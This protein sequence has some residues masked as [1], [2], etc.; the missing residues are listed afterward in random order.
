VSEFAGIVAVVAALNPPAAALMAGAPV[1]LRLAALG[2]GAGLAI[3]A[4]LALL[5]DPFMDLLDV[6]PESF[7]VAAGVVMAAVGTRWLL[8]GWTRRRPAAFSDADAVH[9]IALPAIAGPAT[10]AV[11]MS[12]SANE[13][14]GWALLGIVI[15]A[16]AGAAALLWANRIAF[17]TAARIVAVL[18]I[19]MGAQE[20]VDGVKSV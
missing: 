10:I 13:N 14:V 8:P 15:A 1:P 18:L 7:R 11:S 6:S 2:A 4:L 16:A 3:L 12:I 9:P 5:A 17:E 19:V 20:I